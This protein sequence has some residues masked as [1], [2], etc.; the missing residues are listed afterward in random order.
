MES[1]HNLLVDSFLCFLFFFLILH[2]LVFCSFPI[3]GYFYGETNIMIST[4]FSNKKQL[5]LHSHDASK[6]SENVRLLVV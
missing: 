5:R 6:S 2:L 4:N 3:F 1:H